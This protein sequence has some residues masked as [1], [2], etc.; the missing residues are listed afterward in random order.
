M[1]K[2]KMPLN[3][4]RGSTYALHCFTANSAQQRRLWNDFKKSMSRFVNHRDQSASAFIS[5]V[6]RQWW[7]QDRKCHWSTRL[8][9]R[10]RFMKQ[11][12]CMQRKRA[13]DSTHSCRISCC[14]HVRPHMS[15]RKSRHRVPL[16]TEPLTAQTPATTHA[17]RTSC[18]LHMHC[19]TPSPSP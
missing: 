5:H 19:R 15:H 2:P 16:L 8:R 18:S 7:P 14:P 1:H 13:C 4:K 11:C 3:W 12:N 17:A 10:Q 9:V 6:D